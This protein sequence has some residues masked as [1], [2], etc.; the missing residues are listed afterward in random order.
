MRRGGS[1][2]CNLHEGARAFVDRNM[3]RK[4]VAPA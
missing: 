2:V 3:N 4:Q 1:G